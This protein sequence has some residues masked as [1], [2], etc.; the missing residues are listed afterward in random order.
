MLSRYIIFHQLLTGIFGYPLQLLLF[1]C[2]SQ[3]LGGL[4]CFNRH[5]MLLLLWLLRIGPQR[6]V[7]NA[8]SSL[9]SVKFKFQ[10]H[11]NKNNSEMYRKIS[12]N[13]SIYIITQLY[14]AELPLDNRC[15]L[16]SRNYEAGN[17]NAHRSAP[18]VSVLIE[19][20]VVYPELY[21]LR[22]LHRLKICTVRCS[23]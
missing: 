5:Q 23:L 3:M 13:N 7:K 2:R 6:K 12:Q 22:E 9:N 19:F 20:Q 11:S 18:T 21:Y 17:R 15:E 10:C 14:A 8:Q 4:N 1:S 16:Q